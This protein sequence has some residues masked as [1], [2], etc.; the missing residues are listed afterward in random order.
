MDLSLKE[1]KELIENNQRTCVAD[2]SSIYEV[3]KKYLIRTVTMIQIGRL[4]V[5]GDKELVL[6]DASWI[7]DT[8]R[9]SEALKKGCS[10]LK[11]IEPFQNDC[12]VGRGAIIDATIINFELPSITK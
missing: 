10:V 1:L 8:G 11:E 7:A 4:K 2:T 9:Y 6:E 5:V 3:G 12:I